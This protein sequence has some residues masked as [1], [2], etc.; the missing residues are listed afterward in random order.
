MVIRTRMHSLDNAKCKLVTHLLSTLSLMIFL[1][2]THQYMGRVHAASA[3]LEVVGVH[4]D[5]L[6]HA[7]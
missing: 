7:E 4:R 1:F 6:H 2:T 3:T 5:P